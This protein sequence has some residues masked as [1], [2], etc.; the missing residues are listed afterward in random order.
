[1][2][3]IKSDKL[4][5]ATPIN[6]VYTRISNLSNLGN[7]NMPPQIK[8]WKATENEC[9]FEVE[10]M[11]KIAMQIIEKKAPD[12]VIIASKEGGSP[13][14]FILKF[15]LEKIDSNNCTS[16]VEIDVE[17]N[18]FMATMVKKPLEKFVNILNEAVKKSV[19][20]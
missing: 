13:F 9:S 5:I 8:N 4:S 2:T 20:I 19:E 1:M 18:A 14:P 11:A 6:E 12:S 15:N 10:S 7:G 17:V 3:S 16:M